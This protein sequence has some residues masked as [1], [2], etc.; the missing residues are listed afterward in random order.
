MTRPGSGG[1]PGGP[2]ARS[3]RPER[4]PSV[5]AYQQ[6]VRIDPDFAEA[7]YNLGLAYRRDTRSAEAVG[8]LREA[9]RSRPN[10]IAAHL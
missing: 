5:S 4:I 10:F 2:V 9:G 3:D 1:T 7:Y 6:A 8:A